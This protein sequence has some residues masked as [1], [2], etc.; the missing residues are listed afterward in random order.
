MSGLLPTKRP[1]RKSGGWKGDGSIPPACHLDKATC[2]TVEKAQRATSFTRDNW[3]TAVRQRRSRW[4]VTRL[5]VLDSSPVHTATS[6][7]FHGGC[8]RRRRAVDMQEGRSRQERKLSEERKS[9]TSCSPNYSCHSRLAHQKVLSLTDLESIVERSILHN[10][11]SQGSNVH[12]QIRRLLTFHLTA[13][14]KLCKLRPVQHFAYP[15]HIV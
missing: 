12:G 14:G 2:R 9:H 3:D 6:A 10:H 5:A 11:V 8:G 7:A 1:D 13:M 15:V 4:Y